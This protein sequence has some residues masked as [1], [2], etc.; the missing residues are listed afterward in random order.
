VAAASTAPN[1]RIVIAARSDTTGKYNSFED[2][3]NV[4]W[5]AF[6]GGFPPARNSLSF[7][8]GSGRI[9]LVGAKKWFYLVLPGFT[10]LD[11]ER[12]GNLKPE[13][14]EAGGRPA[15]RQAFWGSF[16][17]SM[18]GY[19]RIWPEK[20]ETGQGAGWRSGKTPVWK[21][22]ASGGFAGAGAPVSRLGAVLFVSRLSALPALCQRTDS[23]HIC[24][25]DFIKVSI[26]LTFNHLR[27]CP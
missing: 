17:I 4:S 9:R 15:F 24:L 1:Q 27:R 10:R 6:P 5:L 7:L 11:P 3:Q 12:A 20:P 13:K 25:T 19:T 21:R 14:P 18:A 2:G 26:Y 8:V 16:I 23:K 22:I